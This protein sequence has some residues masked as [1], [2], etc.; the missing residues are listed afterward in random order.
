MDPINI[1]IGL[2]IIA[3]FGASYSGAK[4]GFKSRLG[5]YKEKPNTY[6]QWLPL[7]FSTI[8]LLLL[9]VSV[10]QVGT[11]EYAEEYQTIRYIGLAFYLIFSWIQ[12]WSFRVLGDSYS[13]EVLIMKD[14]KLI[15][16]GPFKFIRHPQYLSQIL[17]D[18]GAAA[19]TLSYVLF[20][21]AVIQIPFLF[22]RASIEDKLLEKHFGESWKTYKQ[23]SGFFIPFVG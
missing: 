19:A 1:I 16:T 21:F 15:T 8:T 22:M 2:N 13:Q 11:L 20:P 5:A 17:L 18:L 7:T 12:N 9:I 10:F 4:K 23:K 6:L 3:T 14:H